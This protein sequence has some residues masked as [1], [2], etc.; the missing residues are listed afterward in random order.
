MWIKS[1]G[2]SQEIAELIIGVLAMDDEKAIQ[3]AIVLSERNRERYSRG[4]AHCKGGV[5]LV[6]DEMT[7]I[8]TLRRIASVAQRI[9][10]GTEGA[11]EALLGKRGEYFRLTASIGCQAWPLIRGAA[12]ELRGV[13]PNYIFNPQITV[14]LRAIDRAWNVLSWYSVSDTLPLRE[15]RVRKTLD[16]FVA[17]I[18]R[19]MRSRRFAKMVN[20]HTR[21]ARQGYR[22]CCDYIRGLFAKHS[23]LLVLRVDLYY[24]PDEKGWADEEAA[25]KGLRKLRRNLRE[26]RVLPGLLGSICKR[27]NGFM[28]GMHYHWMFF[29]DGHRHRDAA[30]LSKMLGEY[31]IEHCTGDDKKGQYFNCYTRRDLYDLNALGLVHASD[32]KKLMGIREAVRYITKPTHQLKTG[33]DRNLFR[34][35]A[36]TCGGRKR[37]SP[38]KNP[39]LVDVDEILG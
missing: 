37:G 6:V 20:N 31:W 12:N 18:R 15:E 4:L 19:V 7:A 5:Q 16:W 34:G 28:R 14:M 11:Y 1:V 25:Q 29:L 26:G 27:E 21:N 13:Y 38:R 24:L 10:R 35:I 23:R 39:D 9:C 22:S 8:H 30:N 3:N 33:H 2:V 32:R 17:F 36:E